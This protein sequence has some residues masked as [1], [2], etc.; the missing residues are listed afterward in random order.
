MN[1]NIL[2]KVTYKIGIIGQGYV[3]LPL[4]AAFGRVFETVGFDINQHRIKDLQ[5][6]NDQTKQLS[7][8]EIKSA[9]LLSFSSHLQDI[10]NCLYRYGSHTY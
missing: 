4:A 1:K 7:K 6:F 3:G 2:K 10:E 5:Q 8:E 9:H